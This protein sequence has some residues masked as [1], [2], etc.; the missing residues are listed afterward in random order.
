MSISAEVVRRLR[1]ETGAGMMD[2]KSALVE[3]KGDL[4]TDIAHNGGHH[5]VAP[6]SG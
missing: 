2:C 5:G 1:E 4:E 6:G 3:A